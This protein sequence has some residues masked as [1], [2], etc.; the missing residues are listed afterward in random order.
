MRRCE[1]DR[2]QVS[3]EHDGRGGLFALCTCGV[4]TEQDDEH[5]RLHFNVCCLALLCFAFLVLAVCAI[6]GFHWGT[7]GA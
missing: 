5:V 1:Q 3:R 2:L 6:E 7:S 4:R